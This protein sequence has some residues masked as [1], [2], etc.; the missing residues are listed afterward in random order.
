MATYFECPKCKGT[1]EK[2]YTL[3][4]VLIAILLFPLGLVA[5]L[6]PFYKCRNCGYLDRR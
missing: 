1:M 3:F 4:H 5:L 2:K 6:V